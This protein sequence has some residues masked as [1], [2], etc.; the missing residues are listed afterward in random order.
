MIR[1]LEYTKIAPVL[2]LAVFVY[3]FALDSIHI[4]NIGDEAIY[5]QIVRK[6]SERSRWLPL[7]SEEGIKNVKPPLLFWQGMISTGMGKHWTLWNLR[8]PVVLTTFLVALLV[9]LLVRRITGETRKAVLGGLVY[10]GFLST[11]QQGRPFLMHA[12]ETLFLFS[13]LLVIFR[14]KRLNAGRI[15]ICGFLLGMA[16]LYKSFFLVIAGGFALAL[17]LAWESRWNAKSFFRN[18]GFP[19]AGVSILALVL[20]SLWMLLDPRPDLIIQDFFLSENL[21]KFSQG[22]FFS[23]FFSGTYSIFRIWLGNL[24]NSGLYVLVLFALVFDLFKR[25]KTLSDDEKRLW[26]YVLGFLA[27]YSFPTQRQENYILPTCAALSV[28]IA[29]RWDKLSSWAFRASHALL[30]LFSGLAVWL[31]YG[32]ERSLET[33]LFSPIVYAL[34]IL[35]SILG[36]F[37]IFQANLGRRIFPGLVLGLLFVFSLFLRPLSKPFSAEAIKETMGQTVY[38]PSNFFASYE[39]FRFILPGA[40]IQ[41]YPD[42]HHLLPDSV[43]YRAIILRAGDETPSGFRLIDQIFHLRSRHS[44]AEIR[45]ILLRGEF[46]LL[47]GRLALVE[48]IEPEKQ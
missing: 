6:T 16:A 24:A 20:F 44:N 30:V 7:L 41:G 8:I 46:E 28:L 23:G 38:F 31:F 33:P 22:S 13:P 12:A 3:L 34:L 18:Y 26:L 45:A 4:L 9:G 40:D 48:K 11:I 43:R 35:I 36:I 21:S 5:I 1:K 27:I 2:L 32:I 17:V 15:L 42:S 39:I 47:I 25:R 10:L 29:L 19:L 14:I 37:G